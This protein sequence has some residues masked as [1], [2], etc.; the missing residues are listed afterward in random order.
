MAFGWILLLSVKNSWDLGAM[1]EDD[2]GICEGQS[3][4][5]INSTSALKLKL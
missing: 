4:Q 1:I 3:Y 2:P 5:V